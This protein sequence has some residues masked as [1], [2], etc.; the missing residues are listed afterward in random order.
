MMRTAVLGV[1]IFVLLSL[2]AWAWNEKGHMVVA[3]LTW[4]KLSV[5][6]RQAA[7]QIL[8]SHPHYEE[9]LSA[10][11]PAGI[12]PD[13]WAFMRAAYW[14][15][16]VRSNH[17]EEFHKSTW[18]YVTAAIV[19]RQSRVGVNQV[20]AEEQNVVTQIPLCVEKLRSGV[21]ADKPIYLCWLLHLV[22]DI[23]QPLHCASLY[24]ETFPDGDR[25]G[26]LSLVRFGGGMSVRLHF[27]WDSLLGE[28]AAVPSVEETV[29]ELRQIELD[30]AD[31]IHRD[32]I[33]HPTSVG[34]ASEGYASALEYAYLNGDLSPP[35]AA[36]NP[37]DDLVPSLSDGYTIQARKVARL[38]AAKAGQRLTECL[39]R[40]LE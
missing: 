14:P 11:R 33:A 32:L 9:Y 21:Q 27:A 28:T 12:V 35:N 6:T 38:A 7:S 4:L 3:R 15:D 37:S 29:A 30:E 40:A 2:P 18:H 10:D 1:A 20:H 24:N 8:K 31:A 17:S 16:W 39:R 22:G 19:P 34:W 26:N 5:A 25:G 23:H 36:N 13:E